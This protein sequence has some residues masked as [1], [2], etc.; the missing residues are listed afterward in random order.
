MSIIGHSLDLLPA[1]HRKLWETARR[2]LKR[3]VL[4]RYALKEPLQGL[5][6]IIVASSSD[7][8]EML[9]TGLPDHVV[10][11]P[12]DAEVTLVLLHGV[13][14]ERFV[15]GLPVAVL[16]HIDRVAGEDIIVLLT[17]LRDGR[18]GISAV[19]LLNTAELH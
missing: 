19:K 17:V 2:A 16:E 4:R 5:L 18:S 8:A 14:A 1:P 11:H 12:S 7:F 9:S 10:Q 13:K 15:G 6:A 3:E